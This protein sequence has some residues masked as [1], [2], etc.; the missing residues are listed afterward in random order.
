MF[1]LANEAIVIFK[2]KSAEVIRSHLKKLMSP[3]RGKCCWDWT[4]LLTD[5]PSM[6]SQYQLSLVVTRTTLTSSAF[7]SFS[8]TPDNV[9]CI[10]IRFRAFWRLCGSPCHGSL[11]RVQFPAFQLKPINN[12]SDNYNHTEIIRF[13]CWCFV[14]R[15]CGIQV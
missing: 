12:Y 10:S 1:Q 8:N 4:I 5:A 6:D 14:K 15:L 7:S 3:R 13:G 9:L 2:I 11:T